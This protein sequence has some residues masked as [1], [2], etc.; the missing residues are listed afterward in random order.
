MIDAFAG[1]LLLPIDAIARAQAAGPVTREML[2]SYAARYRTSWMLALRQAEQAQIIDAA[3]RSAWSSP[4]PIRAE[5][6]EALGWAPEPDLMAVRVPPGYA[7][8]VIKAWRGNRITRARAVEM[9]YGQITDA[10]LPEEN[11][12]ELPP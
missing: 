3:T 2:I 12:T 8:A 11:D 6:M 9:M 4:R 10:D 5:F 1:E 7:H